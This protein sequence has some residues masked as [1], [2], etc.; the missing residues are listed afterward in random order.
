MF[1][2]IKCGQVPEVVFFC[3]CI[4]SLFPYRVTGVAM[5]VSRRLWLAVFLE[6]IAQLASVL[7]IP[8][9]CSGIYHHKIL[10]QS[11]VKMYHAPPLLSFIGGVDP[12]N[13]AM[14]VL[15]TCT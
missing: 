3:G 6:K 4:T 10:R 5:L 1:L 2:T 11:C 15:H 7:H 14:Y 9:T 12:G 8:C 13:K